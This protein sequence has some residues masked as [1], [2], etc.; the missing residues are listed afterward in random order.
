MYIPP[1]QL[2]WKEIYTNIYKTTL[3]TYLRQ[4]QYRIV[5]NYITVNANLFNW[6]LSETPRCSY[7]FTE[8]ETTEHLFCEC[9]IAI[10]LYRQIE[11]WASECSI[12]MPQLNVENVILQHFPCNTDNSIKH[13]LILLYKFILFQHRNIKSNISVDVFVQ[14][15]TSIEKIEYKVADKRGKICTH[16]KKW[17]SLLNVIR[18]AT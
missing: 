11:T 3:D 8:R 2:N 14:K 4:F 12:T 16:L 18:D 17:S 10:T 7:C 15:V 6:K 13:L 5:H 9:N 1:V